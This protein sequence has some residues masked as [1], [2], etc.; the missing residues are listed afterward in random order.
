[1][2]RTTN[3]NHS[4]GTALAGY[5]IGLEPSEEFTFRAWLGLAS[6]GELGVIPENERRLLDIY[7][8]CDLI[9]GYGPSVLF[10]FC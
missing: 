10:E 2:N 5:V 3:A 6:L 4:K 9:Q 8:L 7:C 1:M